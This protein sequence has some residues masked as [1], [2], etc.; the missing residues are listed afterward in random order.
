MNKNSKLLTLQMM[1]EIM[2]YIQLP[3]FSGYRVQLRY[4]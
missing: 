3:H 4:I 2:Y 1:L